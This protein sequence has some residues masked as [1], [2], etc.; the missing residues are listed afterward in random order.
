[1]PPEVGPGEPLRGP[2][3]HD[4]I[5]GLRRWVVVSA[6]WAVAAT[7]VALIALLDPSDDDAA[8]RA[9]D[10]QSRATAVERPLD[11]RL[12]DLESRL[13]GLPQTSDV[14]RLGD[15]LKAAEDKAAS[16]TEDASSA[17]SATDDLEERVEQLEDDAGSADGQTP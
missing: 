12:D 7:A 17:K 15:R 4:E 9:G 16:A 1:M 13:E 8:K 5:R 10:A 14:S 11:R 3:T 2:V 6:V